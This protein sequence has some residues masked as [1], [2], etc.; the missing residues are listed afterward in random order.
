MK[1]IFAIIIAVLLIV[2]TVLPAYAADYGC[3]VETTTNAVYMENLDTGN[4]VFEKNSTQKV[5]PASTTK[6][7]TYI[8]VSENVSDLDGTE[9]EIKE[10]YFT[11]MDPESSVMGLTEHIGETVSVR[12]LLYGLMLPSGNDAALMLANYVGGSVSGFVDMMNEK[13]TE[14]HC[15]NTRFTSPHGLF[16]EDHYST[17]QDMATITKYAM[18]LPGFMEICSSTHHEVKSYSNSDPETIE[19]T[20]YLIDETQKGGYY[21]YSYAKGIKTG[22]TDEA[23]RCLV[24]TAV[25]DG[26]T[27]LIVALGA[28]YDY[29]EDINYAMLDS[30]ELY[31]WAFEHIAYQTVMSGT[32][33][34]G[35]ADVEFAKDDKK[36]NLVPSGDVSSLLPNDYD[37]A[38]VTTEVQVNENI[39]APVKQGDILGSVEVYLD[40]ELIDTK[41]VIAADS[42]ERD[43]F[44]YTFHQIKEFFKTHVVLVIILGV[45]LIVV[46]IIIIAAVNSAK[47][48]KKRRERERSR[49][50]YRDND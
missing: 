25:K 44:K 47:K 28:A 35:Q 13:V 18:E 48:A 46:I 27:Y 43:E 33:S 32:D 6:I 42:V 20:N 31:E 34:L 3:D 26:Y 40:G 41:D 4:V 5:Y 37:K 8:V 7:L 16:D 10:E 30:K 1:R 36:I 12:D 2:L 11:E 17:A 50:R 49:R 14:L 9:L 19:T 21:Y 24:S 22:F 38:R 45:V 29:D 23:G 39:E 15:E